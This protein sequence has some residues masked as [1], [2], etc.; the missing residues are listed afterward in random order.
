MPREI[1]DKSRMRQ[2]RGRIDLLHPEDYNAWIHTRDCFHGDGTRHL[3]P[4]LFYEKRVIH[5][6]SDLEKQVYYF[7]RS[8][9]KILELFEQFPLLPLSK[10]EDICKK[11]NIKP[12]QNPITK[13]NIVMTT[14]FLI[15]FKENNEEKKWVACAVKP[16]SKLEDQRTKE[17]LFIE[18]KYWET[19]GVRWGILSELQIDSIYVKNIILCRNGYKGPIN[20][21]AYNIVKFLI[22]YNLINVDLHKL[23]DLDEV[24]KDIQ[25]GRIKIEPDICNEKRSNINKLQSMFDFPKIE[26]VLFNNS[27]TNKEDVDSTNKNI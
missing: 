1:S 23:I 20:Y 27:I 15:I 3:I 18:R 17:K 9:E 22:V 19:L 6:L 13:K 11:Y 8:N 5:L 10:T 21:T 24:I 7:L 25:K 2:K 14:D 12:P 4:D 16:S 26:R